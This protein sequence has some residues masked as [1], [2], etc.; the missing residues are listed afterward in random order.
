M[1]NS[2]NFEWDIQKNR[3]NQLKHGGIDFETASRV[4]A[5][6]ELVLRKDR[7]V[8]GESSAGTR[9]V[10]SGWL[11]CSLCM[12]I[13]RRM[14]MA[15]KLSA[16]SQ[17]GKL[18]RVNAESIWNKPLTE[19]QKATLDRMAKRQKRGD[20]SRI[21]YSDIPALT[22]KQLSEFRRAPKKLVAVR[23]DADVLEWLQKFGAGYSTRINSVL[24]AVMAQGKP[25]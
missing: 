2:V 25:G 5:D 12:F 21:E 15:R 23:L 10:W 24:R 4:F 22:D 11:C 6:P 7:V 16:S 19:R 18:T 14:Q 13:E 17:H 1:Y 9:S 8:D 20:V 3:A